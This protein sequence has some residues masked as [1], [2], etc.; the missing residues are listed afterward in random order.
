MGAVGKFFSFSEPQFSSHKMGLTIATLEYDVLI[1]SGFLWFFLSRLQTGGNRSNPDRPC[2]ICPSAVAVGQELEGRCISQ[3]NSTNGREIYL[4]ISIDHLY[5]YVGEREGKILRR[6]WFTQLWG[7]ASLKSAGWAG[8]LE[9]QGWAEVADDVQRQ[10][11]GRICSCWG[12]SAFRSVQAFSWL[13][14]AHPPSGGHSALLRVHWFKC[15]TSSQE[16]P[17]ECLIKYLA[18][19]AQPG[20]NKMNHH[21]GALEI[22]FL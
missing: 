7:L 1:I 4:S 14:E 3:G 8:R 11:A 2:S 16:H 13:D 20:W 10:P 18:T 5:I 9:T 15:K 17:G 22:S 21:T 19:V 12:R 6:N